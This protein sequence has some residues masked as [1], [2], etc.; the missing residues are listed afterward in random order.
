M[1]GSP[2]PAESSSSPEP[3]PA[4]ETAALLRA[5]NVRAS[6]IPTL[7]HLPPA[8]VAAV[9]AVAQA[10]PGLRDVA[11]WVV[12]TLRATRAPDPADAAALSR[13]LAAQ[14]EPS[15]GKPRPPAEPGPPA[16]LKIARARPARPDG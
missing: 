8:Q 16:G 3:T 2:A 11:S 14:K 4:E 15:V 5:I 13:A 1:D 12:S 6:T 7:T 9:I 10:K